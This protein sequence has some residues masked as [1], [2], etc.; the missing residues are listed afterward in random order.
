MCG[1]GG[2]RTSAAR[3]CSYGR[4][5]YGDVEDP[6][7]EF[8]VQP[9]AEVAAGAPPGAAAAAGPLA[10]LLAGGAAGGSGDEAAYWEWHSGFAV[11]RLGRALAPVT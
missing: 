4:L 1:F 5:M 8:F 9:G 7:Q 2:V 11:R 10:R 3:V 6:H